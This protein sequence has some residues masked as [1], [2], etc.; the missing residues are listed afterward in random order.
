MA[1]T[2]INKNMFSSLEST[3]PDSWDDVGT[4]KVE[5]MSVETIEETKQTKQIEKPNDDAKTSKMVPFK[6][7]T[8]VAFVKD[9]NDEYLGK[10]DK[11]HTEKPVGSPKTKQ[12]QKKVIRFIVASSYN[13]EK[14]NHRHPQYQTGDDPRSHAFAKMDDKDAMAKS[15]VGT[16]AC[17][18]VKRGSPDDEFGVCY[19]MVCT[20]AHSLLELNDPMCGFDD[21][22]RFMNGKPRRDG[23]IDKKTKCKFRHSNETRDDWVKRTGRTLPD[24]P[25]TNEKTRKPT[26]RKAKTVPGPETPEQKVQKNTPSAPQKELYNK[27]NKTT[28]SKWG[29]RVLD[30]NSTV[31]VPL[32]T[33][34][35]SSESDRRSHRSSRRRSYRSRSYR[36]RSPVRDF[37]PVRK[38]SR[39]ISVQTKELAEIAINAAMDRGIFDLRVIVE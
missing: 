8:V 13:D 24:L 36:S 32:K 9:T 20:F 7:R 38:T 3:A 22:C 23:T 33:D 6:G 37:S 29:V 15:L 1:A 19:R 35:Y 17:N 18:H 25:E 11:K 27:T 14:R 12:K 31:S 30:M 2:T 5:P 21:T 16:R 26:E 4:V 39:T 10:T 28:K 34:D